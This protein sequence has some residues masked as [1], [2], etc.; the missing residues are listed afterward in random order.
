[1]REIR[2][3]GIILVNYARHVMASSKYSKKI[4]LFQAE[5]ILKKNKQ[6]NSMALSPRANY[7]D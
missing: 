2:F 6:T 7:T 5:M 4:I 3:T 1:M